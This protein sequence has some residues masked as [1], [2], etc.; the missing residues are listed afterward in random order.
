MKTIRWHSCVCVKIVPMA[1][2]INSIRNTKPSDLQIPRNDI[3]NSTLLNFDIHRFLFLIM[4]LGIQKRCIMLLLIPLL[5]FFYYFLIVLISFIMFIPFLSFPQGF[6]YL[7]DSSSQAL[8]LG[9]YSKSNPDLL[10]VELSHGT[11]RN[12]G[13]L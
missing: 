8:G 13:H 12:F 3:H 11:L 5:I 4:M 9:S 2:F 10:T 6:R 7:L 1:Q